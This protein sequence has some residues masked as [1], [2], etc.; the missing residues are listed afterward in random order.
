[1][2]GVCT[3]ARLLLLGRRVG[4]A[5]RRRGGARR[6]PARRHGRQ[7]G[8]RPRPAYECARA[9]GQGRS[10]TGVR[11]GQGIGACFSPPFRDSTRG[12]RPQRGRGG[13]NRSNAAAAFYE[14]GRAKAQAGT[15]DRRVRVLGCTA[16]RCVGSAAITR[17]RKHEREHERDRERERLGAH[18][19]QRRHGMA[20]P[21]MRR[22]SVKAAAPARKVPAWHEGQPHQRRRGGAAARSNS[23]FPPGS[24][25]GASTRE[26]ERSSSPRW[27][28][29]V[30][31]A[32]V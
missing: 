17:E 11:G 4:I 26:E 6:S 25:A 12:S 8:R 10:G 32:S 27:P 5:T 9:R 7:R 15:R 2:R 14:R 20:R 28:R 29:A 23:A 21:R 13:A 18:G 19:G 22:A 24:K 1:V 30:A 3:R 31:Q 16:T